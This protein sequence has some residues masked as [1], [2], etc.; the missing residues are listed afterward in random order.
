MWAY[1]HGCCNQA[2]SQVIGYRFYSD[3]SVCVSESIENVKLNEID[4]K[5]SLKEARKD[6]EMQLTRANITV[7]EEKNIIDLDE[8]PEGF[9]DC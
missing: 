5:L 6:V 1:M 2:S 3:N 8:K 4:S 9:C 7:G